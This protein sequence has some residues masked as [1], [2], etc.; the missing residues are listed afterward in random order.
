M[1]NADHIAPEMFLQ[2]G[3]EICRTDKTVKKAH[4]IHCDVAK[5]RSMFRT[6]PCICSVLWGILVN[7]LVSIDPKT[8]ICHLLWA[9]LLMFDCSTETQNGTRVGVDETTFRKWTLPWIAGMSNTSLDVIKW[10]NRFLGNWFFWTFSLDGVHCPIQEP[11]PFWSGWWSHEHDDAGLDYEICVGV[12]TGHIVWIRGP[13][14]AGKW[15]DLKVFDREL[16]GNI[17]LDQEKGVVDGG[18][19]GCERW[20]ATAWWMNRGDTCEQGRNERHE[21]ICG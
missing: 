8:R 3:R 13:F 14:P 9:L 19:P 1:A 2:A 4:L 15:S 7:P 5:F 12:S 6:V 18:H 17:L 21:S 10:E 16:L 20:L 11:S